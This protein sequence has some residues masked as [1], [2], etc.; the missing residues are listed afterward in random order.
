MV[1]NLWAVHFISKDRGGSARIETHQYEAAEIFDV[2]STLVA[3]I[4]VKMKPG[5][6]LK[7]AA[8]NNVVPRG[9]SLGIRLIVHRI[10]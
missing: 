8:S 2:L 1:N 5:E 10:Y 9:A 6:T 4:V 7:F 3:A